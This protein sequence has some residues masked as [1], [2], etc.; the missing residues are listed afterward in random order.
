MLVRRELPERLR[1][2]RR[3]PDRPGA[4]PGALPARRPR[5]DGRGGRRACSW[6]PSRRSA[7]SSPTLLRGE[8]IEMLLGAETLERTAPRGGGVR[9]TVAARGAHPGDRR[10][11]DP[12]SAPA[13]RPTSGRCTWTAPAW[14]A[15]RR[16]MPV[17][18]RLQT[19]QGGHF[20]AG[21]VLGPPFGAYTHT[22]RALGRG[23]ASNALDVDPHDV[24][25]RPRPRRDL[26]RP[27]VR[28]HRAHRGRGAGEGPRHRRR[29]LR[30]LGRQGPRVGA[31]ARPGEGGGRP[32]LPTRS[33][34]PRSWR[35]TAPT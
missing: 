33:W 25:P 8:G 31:G 30:L 15:A 12:R 26:H 4:R 13:G 23:A 34:A 32:R 22:A 3:G 20:A 5:D 35:T 1:R 7:T 2:D 6:P 16:A 24:E 29:D 9:V 21:D 17:D 11:R 18:A 14:T 28:V 10:R 27:G 19:S